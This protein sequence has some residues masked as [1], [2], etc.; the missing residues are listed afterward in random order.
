MPDCVHKTK[1]THKPR[2]LFHVRPARNFSVGRLKT[3]NELPHVSLATI[4]PAL[5]VGSANDPLEREAENTAER[6]VSTPSPE[7]APHAATSSPFSRNDRGIP[8][9]RRAA[10]DNQPNLD[11]LES[12]PPIP[13]DHQDPEVP[14][15]EDVDTTGL[16]TDDMKE[17]ESGQPEDTAGEAPA[18]EPPPPTDEQPVAQPA[19]SGETAMVG[20]EGGAAPQDVTARVSQPGSGRA[21]PDSLRT[22]ME[23]RFGKDF[24]DVR[25]HDAPDDR[26]AARRIGARAFTHRQHIWIGPG[27][28]VEN[29]RLM[30]H[31]LTHVVQQTKRTPV[32]VIKREVEPTADS[33]EPEVR[34]GY[35]RDKAEKYARKVPG[36]RLVSVIL[37]K[38]PITGNRVERNGTNLL[39][40]LMSMIPGGGILFDR[41]METRVIQ[42]AFEW[43]NT[44]LH[45]LNI[46]W[47]RIKGLISEL[48]D[49]IPAWPSNAIRKAK[50][51]FAPIVRDILTFIREVKDKI[52]E[53]IIRGALK[54][55]GPLAEKVWGVIKK[56]G[57]V[58][59]TILEDP[60]QFAKNLFNSVLKGFRQFG[61]N[62]FTHIKKGL[63][64]WLFGAIQG[65]EITIPEKLDFKGLISIGLQIV[66]LTYANFRAKLVKRLGANGERK[67][68]YLEKSVEVVKILLKEGFVGIWQRVLQMIEN[69][70]Q[71]MIGGIQKFVIETLIKGGLSWLA[72]LS[73]PV[74][75]VVKVVLAIYNM[76]KTFLE[77]LDQILEVANSIFNSVGAIAVGKIQ[78]AANFIE[79]TI[80]ATIPV[81]ISFLAALVPVTGITNSIRGIIKK[82]RAPV[83]KAM[84]KM[85][86]FLV[87]KAKKLFSK[88]IGK[89]NSKRQLPSANFKIGKTSRRIYA[90]KKGKSIQVMIAYRKGTPIEQVDNETKAEAKKLKGEDAKKIGTAITGKGT[91]ANNETAKVKTKVKLNLKNQNQNKNLKTL[92]TEIDKAAKEMGEAG[93]AAEGNAEVNEE[94]GGNTPLFRHKPERYKG[95]G[96]VDTWSALKKKMDADQKAAG[97]SGVAISSIFERDHIPTKKTLQAIEK[98]IKPQNKTQKKNTSL[99]RARTQAK[100]SKTKQDPKP[101][102]LLHDRSTKVNAKSHYAIVLYAKIHAGKEKEDG[103]VETIASSKKSLPNKIQDFKDHLITHVKEQTDDIRTSYKTEKLKTIK[104]KVNQGLVDITNKAN[105]NF[106]LN[107]A[108][109]K[110]PKARAIP[111]GPRETVLF[112]PKDKKLNFSGNEGKTG[113]HKYLANNF[114]MRGILESDHLIDDA[115][116]QAVRKQ[117]NGSAWTIGDI[118]DSISSSVEKHIKTL[119][120]GGK[121]AARKRYNTAKK[122]PI[123]SSPDMQSY[124]RDKGRAILIFKDVHDA[125]DQ[126]DRDAV[127]QKLKKKFDSKQLGGLQQ[128]VKGKSNDTPTVLAEN[129]RGLIKPFFT[130]RFNRHAK[131]IQEQYEKNQRNY[132]IGI[133]PKNKKTAG[134]EM[135]R[136]IGNVKDSIKTLRDETKAL[137]D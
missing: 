95:E 90:E 63:L 85:I 130:K 22:F 30:A 57:N 81:V 59:S 7:M 121:I 47:T 94:A 27:E 39:G 131:I 135:D 73:N 101:L 6:I 37:G 88:I 96:D 104:N 89:L 36:Y 29:R 112:K 108:D 34:R 9:A 76:I 77:R 41:L 53:F 20:A 23:P 28:S 35:I 52:L 116:P 86:A 24:S 102:G 132:V 55:A 16:T 10:A 80:A 72:G 50:S 75:A 33:E 111:A 124:T 93:K 3:K 113:S 137:F 46:T 31:E 83:D 49:Y 125:V 56:G 15:E 11:T 65:L 107:Q 38:S 106:K 40:A 129:L 14:Q 74:G 60:L 45:S 98:V 117:K 119:P 64:G 42:N 84:E 133:N 103:K 105:E 25:I 21:L 97:T 44:R 2:I 66:G 114:S 136:I 92:K 70:K 12:A 26:H 19:R 68:A 17:I 120:T 8:S 62:V 82:L 110:R 61:S 1:R 99:K 100:N 79:K 118:S 87:K 126:P 109:I 32:S 122:T 43:V 58:I 134:D 67:V 78:Q 48:L 5:K 18:E 13:A 71:T 115:F 69:F 127:Q 4:Q 128:Y 123:F 54:L 91:E 51:L